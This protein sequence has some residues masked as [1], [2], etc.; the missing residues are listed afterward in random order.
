VAEVYENITNM[1]WFP[2]GLGIKHFRLPFSFGAAPAFT[3]FNVLFNAL[4]GRR[5][6]DDPFVI[7]DKKILFGLDRTAARGY[8]ARW[9]QNAVQKFLEAWERFAAAEE[10]TYKGKFRGQDRSCFAVHY[11]NRV[12]P[13]FETDP[14]TVMAPATYIKGYAY[15]EEPQSSMD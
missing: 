3:G 4:I 11:N 6:M 1:K 14:E 10:E 2:N 7:Q 9:R 8:F 5:C 13:T 15:P 12:K